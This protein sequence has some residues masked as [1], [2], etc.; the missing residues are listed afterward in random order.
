M[1]AKTANVTNINDEGFMGSNTLHS[2]ILSPDG[3]KFNVDGL[4]TNRLLRKDEW[5]K[6]DTAVVEIQRQ[7]L[8]GVADLMSRGLTQNLGG[9]GTTIVEWEA[10]SDMR[11]AEIDMAGVTPGK[12]DSVVF[13]TQGVP[14]PITHRDYRINIRRLLAGR[15][16]GQDIDVTQAEVAS[17]K[18]RDMLENTLFNGVTLNVGGYSIYG[19]TT[20]PQRLRTNIVTAWDSATTTILSDIVHMI[21][22]LEAAFFFGPFTLYVPTNYWSVLIED[23]STY[24]EGTFLDRILRY[25]QIES[26]KV[27][28]VMSSTE[29]V[30]VQLTRDVVEMAIGQDVTNVEWTSMGGLLQHNKIMAA[31]V[32]KLK[33]NDNGTSGICHGFEAGT[34]TTSTAA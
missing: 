24:K 33:Y 11:D 9:L 28:D 7:R 15:N 29:V 4:R 30:M 8:T 10:V 5:L 19:Y 2:N 1:D 31:M 21:A 12:E 6:L 20:F 14:V 22:T 3:L 16:I 26:V 32:Q 23:Y 17:R 25:P 34:S 27:A 18:V 13:S